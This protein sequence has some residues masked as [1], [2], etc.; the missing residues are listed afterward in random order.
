MVMS[1]NLQ[2]F[3]FTLSF[4]EVS[5]EEQLEVQR[6]EELL[7]SFK[8]GHLQGIEEGQIIGYENAQK[9]IE[10]EILKLLTKFSEELALF[11]KK[12]DEKRNENANLSLNLIQLIGKKLYLNNNLTDKINLIEKGL[13][14]VLPLLIEEEK[15]IL[16]LEES[17]IEPFTKRLQESHDYINIINRLSFN[18]M[19]PK[20]NLIGRIQWK[21]GEIDIN[22]E[23]LW[24]K[25]SAIFDNYQKHLNSQTKTQKEN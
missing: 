3:N 14:D 10:S 9:S 21:K 22:P 8:K 24:E 23:H 6:Q 17:L 19:S 18:I 25:I 12:I 15:I 4:D 16:N 2:K 7:S 11:F 1:N 13:H 5:S 20:E